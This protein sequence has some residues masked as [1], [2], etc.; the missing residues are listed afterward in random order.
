M[1]S[2]NI[3]RLRGAAGLSQEELAGK[4]HVVRQTVSKWDKGLSVPDADMLIALSRALGCSPAE[5]LGAAAEELGDP[6]P[7]DELAGQLA[8]L[9]ARLAEQLE[10]NRR[11]RRGLSMAAVAAACLAL[12]VQLL[13]RLHGFFT[14]LYL[15]RAAGGII[16]GADGPTAVYISSAGPNWPM[17]AIL[18]TLLVLGIFGLFRTRKR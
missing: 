15:S 6:I 14:G 3:K 11:L 4:L 12:P 17:L 18:A 5:L 16:G 7:A 2:D 8:E 1:L 9:N 10:K 13:P